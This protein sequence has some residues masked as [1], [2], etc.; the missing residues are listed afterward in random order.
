M[1]IMSAGCHN[2]CMR[3][4]FLE[5]FVCTPPPAPVK[6][7][8]TISEKETVGPK[9]SPFQEVTEKTNQLVGGRLCFPT[10]EQVQELSVPALHR[11]WQENNLT[12]LGMVSQTQIPNIG[13]HGTTRDGV[14]GILKTRCSKGGLFVAACSSQEKNPISFLAD[15]YTIV[16]RSLNYAQANVMH[17]E[18]G[19]IFLIDMS[20]RITKEDYLEFPLSFYVCPK[21][22]CKS[23]AS[24]GWHKML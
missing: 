10:C 18:T 15:L 9:K 2:C 13:F 20:H 5:E 6:A 19:G 14:D 12:L 24:L 4:D 11:V 8:P 23:K 3:S 21:L 17:R 16:G 1:S 7:V 22:R